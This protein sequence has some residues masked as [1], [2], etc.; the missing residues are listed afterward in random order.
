MFP[1][2]SSAINDAFEDMNKE[3]SL[4]HR[5]CPQS[6]LAC[7]IQPIVMASAFAL[8]GFSGDNSP[9]AGGAKKLACPP[10]DRF[11]TACPHAIVHA[12]HGR[13]AFN[14]A[15]VYLGGPTV[16]NEHTT[17]PSYTQDPTKQNMHACA[18]TAPSS[19]AP[20]LVRHPTSQAV[21][22]PSDCCT[23][24]PLF[25]AR[26][27]F[28]HLRQDWSAAPVQRVKPGTVR[29]GCPHGHHRQTPRPACGESGRL[30]LV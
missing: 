17:F 5:N 12:S 13:S 4:G 27:L 15:A 24:N 7:P 23:A 11:P 22:L 9:P 28:S 16:E 14:P 8:S 29:R 19:V 30:R 21:S 18:Q 26:R 1:L 10:D 6:F 2:Q 20:P 25:A 3:N